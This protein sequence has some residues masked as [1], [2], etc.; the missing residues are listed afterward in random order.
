MF[1]KLMSYFLFEETENERTENE[2]TENER[3]ENERTENERT[4]SFLKYFTFKNVLITTCVIS[5]GILIYYYYPEI[6]N[7]LKKTPPPD[8]THSKII[9]KYISGRI[10]GN[11]MLVLPKAGLIF[12][13]YN[14][15]DILNDR[16]T[17]HQNKVTFLSKLS[18]FWLDPSIPIFQCIE[19]GWRVSRNMK[20]YLA[21][22]KATT[23]LQ[24]KPTF[25]KINEEKKFDME[26]VD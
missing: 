3:T 6:I 18:S 5:G 10:A 8:D 7:F 24:K 1:L 2:R 14:D 22:W 15:T 11:S 17:S 20:K 4:V 16:L 13:H 9:K 25:S 12:T 21:F 26:D 19:D 23:V